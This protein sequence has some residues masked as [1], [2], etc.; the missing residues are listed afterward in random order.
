M[1]TKINFTINSEEITKQINE[2]LLAEAKNYC[3][4]FAKKAYEKQIEETTRAYLTNPSSAGLSS[5]VK[6]VIQDVVK[7]MLKDKICKDESIKKYVNERIDYTLARLVEEYNR[8]INNANKEL[9]KK[10]DDRI[11]EIFSQSLVKNII[12]AIS[13]D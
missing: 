9:D 3:R 2:V 6:A 4:N 7:D 11:K 13:K 1:K 12:G 8:Y 5:Y 10:I